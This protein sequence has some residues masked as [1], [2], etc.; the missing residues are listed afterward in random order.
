MNVL[1]IHSL[2]NDFSQRTISQTSPT[3]IKSA[4]EILEECQRAIT[5]ITHL[6]FQ[7]NSMVCNECP[8]L[9]SLLGETNTADIEKVVHQI[10]SELCEKLGKISR[11]V[12]KDC[13][14]EQFLNEMATTI[15]DCYNSITDKVFN[16]VNSVK[17]KQ[18]L[19]K[20]I[21][22]VRSQLQQR[23]EG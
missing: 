3:G 8:Q 13:T 9:R 11:C 4:T 14:I 18:E 7:L 2:S 20:R 21:E 12:S 17:E 5:T 22:A 16:Y 10:I 6:I 1:L 19:N 15:F 23:F